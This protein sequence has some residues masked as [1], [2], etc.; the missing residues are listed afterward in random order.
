M[1]RQEFTILQHTLDDVRLHLEQ[2]AREAGVVLE[3]LMR[4]WNGRFATYNIGRPGVRGSGRRPYRVVGRIK[5]NTHPDGTLHAV[6]SPP[7][8]CDPNPTPDDEAAYRA[9]WR[10]FRAR[11]D[12]HIFVKDN[13]EP[14]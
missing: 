12:G 3:F 2:A 9:F 8:A 10:A 14:N 6:L 11:L 4:R 7:T 13:G 1:N 5:F